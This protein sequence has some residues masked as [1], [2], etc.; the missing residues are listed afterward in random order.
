MRRAGTAEAG[1]GDVSNKAGGAGIAGVGLG[2]EKDGEGETTMWAFFASHSARF[3]L[4][5]AWSFSRYVIV[6]PG[7]AILRSMLGSEM[8]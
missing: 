6:V 1:L 8:L 4:L 2:D 5:I 3:C 7:E